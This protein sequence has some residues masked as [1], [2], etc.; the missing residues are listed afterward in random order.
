MN[1][2]FEIH[3]LEDRSSQTAVITLKTKYDG[4]TYSYGSLKFIENDINEQCTLSFEYDIIQ[5]GSYEKHELEND[6]E[7]ITHIGA[8][9]EHIIREAVEKESYR[10]G[11]ATKDSDNNSKESSNQ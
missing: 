5:P 10:I 6:V 3:D 1:D 7:F 8:I 2:L 9:L 11:D 4:V